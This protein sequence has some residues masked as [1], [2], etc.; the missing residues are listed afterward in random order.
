[1]RWP[2]PRSA[3]LLP[4]LVS[5]AAC[6][7]GGGAATPAPSSSVAPPPT[8]APATSAPTSSP[9]PGGVRLQRV[10]SGLDQPVD[11]VG[12]PGTSDLAIVQKTGLVRIW[13]DRRL[14]SKPLLDLTGQVSGSS[15]Q[16]LLSIAFSPGYASN[17]RAYIDYTDLAGDTHVAQ[18]DTRT[19]SMH[20]I[21]FVHQPYPNH[22]GGALAFGPDG[23]LYVGMGDGGSEGDPQG[24]GQNP[25][26]LLGKI[27]RLDVSRPNPSPQ[28]YARGLRNPWR[29]SFDPAT[30][31]LWIGD[32][33]QNRYEEVDELRAGRPAGANLGWNLMEGNA[34]YAPGPL[35]EGLV[36][37]VAVY[38]HAH[39]C[40]ITGGFVYRG[41][42]V[43][44][45]SGRYV[46]GDFCSGTIWSLPAAGG[47]YR[48]VDVPPVPQLSSFG[49]DTSGELYAVSLSGAVYRFAAAS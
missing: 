22:N 32:V 8:S 2:I 24:N 39:G 35:P 3:V 34:R 14:R 23:R 28:I 46:F 26:V 13:H 25:H 38:S 20:T 44:A 33:G 29:F 36:A 5:A 43:P 42:D 41:R 31:D 17:H 12:V 6:G 11:V 10:V 1:M 18:V 21:L 49:T 15:E 30:G 16:G 45:L 19:G 9:P 27:L 47:R 48:R 37:P 4:L 40:S 7:G